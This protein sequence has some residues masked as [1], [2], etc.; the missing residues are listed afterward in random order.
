[1]DNITPTTPTVILQFT[2]TGFDATRVFAPAVTVVGNS[3][4]MLFGGLP[5]GNNEQIGLATS[6][7]GITWSTGPNPVFSNADSQPWASFREIPVTLM[8]VN[9]V[10]DAWFNG[11]NSNLSSDPGYETGFG[12]A[13]STDGGQTWTMSPANPIRETS[14]TPSGTDVNLIGVVDFNDKFVSYYASTVSGSTTFYTATSTDGATFSNDTQ[15][16]GVP[17]GY[18]LLAI[19]ATTQNGVPTIFSVWQ[20]GSTEYYGLSNDGINFS[21][22]G[23]INLPSNFTTNNILI[24]NGQIQFFGTLDEGNVNWDFDN[25]AIAEATAPLPFAEGSINP[26]SGLMLASSSDSGIQSD[27]VTKV[28][29]PT[30]SGFGEAGDTVTLFDGSSPIGSG[31]VAPNGSWSITS[32]T[33]LA[34]GQHVLTAVEA[35]ANNDVSIASGPLDLTIKTSAPAPSERSFRTTGLRQRPL[36]P[37]SSGSAK[38]GIR[39]PSSTEVLL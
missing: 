39:S 37:R 38:R 31:Q 8:Y 11:D 29:T 19:S 9:G 17:S 14:N 22:G 36:R 23:S 32:S 12:F 1:M 2:G 15:I 6:T 33:A 10:Y 28:T 35:D 3:Y 13:T 5:F 18:S 34:P 16:M 21:I 30:I 25:Q 26:P 27:N 20:N 4:T 24:A 7:D